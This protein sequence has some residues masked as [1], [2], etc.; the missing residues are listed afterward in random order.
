[1]HTNTIH[2]RQMNEGDRLEMLMNSDGDGAGD[3]VAMAKALK[4]V[5]GS[6][7]MVMVRGTVWR[8]RRY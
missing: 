8:W 3:G 4:G 6:I 1:M 5:C 2:Q 7:V